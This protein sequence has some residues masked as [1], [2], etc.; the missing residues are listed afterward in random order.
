MFFHNQSARLHPHRRP[1]R[2]LLPAGGGLALL[3]LAL[4]GCLSPP[5]EPGDGALH[6]HNWWNY[7]ARGLEALRQERVAEAADAF[8]RCL[9]LLDGARFGNDRDRW[10]ARTY[11]LHFVEGYFPNRELG[12]CL[13][14]QRD[15]EGALRHLGRSLEQAP[16]GRAKHYLNLAR[17]RQLSGR[18]LPPPRLR[19]DPDETAAARPTRDRALTVLGVAEGEGYIRRLAIGHAPEFIELAVP[20][21]PFSR[22]VSLAEGTNRIEITAV[23]LCGRGVTR[24]I[25]RVAD[26]QPPRVLVRT[27]R[28][29]GSRWVLEGVCRDP[30][31]VASVLLDGVS[32]LPDGTL[33]ATDVPLRVEVPADGALLTVTDAAGN[34]LTFPLAE[35]A[36]AAMAPDRPFRDAAA[37]LAFAAAA[38]GWAPFLAETRTGWRGQRVAGTVPAGVVPAGAAHPGADGGGEADRLRPSLVLRGCQPLVRVFAGEFFIDGVAADGGGLVRVTVNGENLLAPADE[39]VLRAYFAR[40]LALD[41]GTNRFEIAATDRQ[42]NRT[43]QQVTVIRMLPEHLDAR[44][45]LTVG[46]PPLIPAE[47]GPAGFRVKRR[48]EAELT[49]EPVRFRLLERDEGW[50]YVLREQGLSLSDLADPAAALRIGKL[51]PAELLLMGTLFIEPKGVT[52]FLRAVE[53]EN[54]EIVFTSDVYSPD[55]ADGLDEA[56]AGLV[57]KVGQGFPLVS[58]QVWKRQGTQFVLNVGR[59]DGTTE[60]SRFLVFDAGSA[61]QPEAVHLCKAD[62]R[63]VQLRI[64]RLQ[65]T[66]STAS[67]QPSGAE[68]LVKEGC[69]VYS[70]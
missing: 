45:R 27:L 51:L 52:V 40:R 60:K 54:G 8:R 30:H 19:L 42:G 11:G 17:A 3:L 7:Y 69:H 70:R 43:A 41:P 4:A 36:P 50:D 29:R 48:M 13:Y 31:G 10:R 14:E 39:G 5:A 20:A 57:L 26:W 28:A 61:A 34:L 25:V 16:S 62:G 37:R 59:A 38:P 58:G 24:H 1:A 32:V 15:D 67:A 2:I 21:L 33:P 49:R 46:V 47:A 6:R 63:P 65:Q 55:A 56:V 9:G 68:A 22:R 23:D 12:V 44:Y 64:E 53:T 18:S 35:G 66:T